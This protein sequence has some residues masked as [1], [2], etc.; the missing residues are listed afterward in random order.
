METVANSVNPESVPTVATD[1]QGKGAKNRRFQNFKAKKNKATEKNIQ[2]DILARL[3]I[4]DPSTVSQ[5]PDTSE[6]HPLTVNVTFNKLPQLIDMIWMRATA[7][8]TRS[9]QELIRQH[10]LAKTIYTK[11][12]LHLAEAKV[13]FAQRAH[14]RLPDNASRELSS[15]NLFTHDEL[16]ILNKVG[17]SLPFPLAMYLESIGNGQIDN[18]DYVPVLGECDDPAN[19]PFKGIYNYS[20][21]Q[22]L[23]LIRFV[24]DNPHNLAIINEVMLMT[25]E[26]P[27]FNWEE[28]VA[29]GIQLS[30]QTLAFFQRMPTLQERALFQ[31][32]NDSLRSLK[33][34]IVPCDLSHGKGGLSQLP[35]QLDYNI[36]ASTAIICMTNIPAY[37]FIISAAFGFG[38]HPVRMKQTRYD[39]VWP[40][41]V[42]RG[43]QLPSN[44]LMHLTTLTEIYAN[45]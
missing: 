28:V 33:G 38:A 18:C 43:V 10:P 13:C 27:G 12:A 11:V 32:I 26:L 29:E 8:G 2:D 21:S 1:R 34:F 25:T 37:D 24:H 14:K 35:R 36:D 42:Q 3:G 9:F 20:I 4:A 7:I 6:N 22:L 19:I 17:E 41:A 39:G 45:K 23:P 44:V 30:P 31:S 5:L 15:L 40:N 16:M